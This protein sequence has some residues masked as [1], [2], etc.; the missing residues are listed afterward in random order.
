MATA[1]FSLRVCAG[2]CFNLFR[3]PLKQ[4]VVWCWGFYLP[5]LAQAS[6]VSGRIKSLGAGAVPPCNL[7]HAVLSHQIKRAA[8]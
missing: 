6:P 2:V 5:A 8:A 7:L 4:P 3:L 1:I